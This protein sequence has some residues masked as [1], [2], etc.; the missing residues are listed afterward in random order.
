[1][2]LGGHP[3]R[4]DLHFREVGF[5]FFEVGSGEGLN[6]F[7]VVEATGVGQDGELFSNGVKR[8][9]IVPFPEGR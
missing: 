9:S 3:G 5:E 7:E 8:I 6:F 2:V 1:M 4:S